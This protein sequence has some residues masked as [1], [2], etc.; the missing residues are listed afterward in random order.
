MASFS[1]SQTQ[2]MNRQS[3]KQK[4]I[5]YYSLEEVAGAGHPQLHAIKVKQNHTVTVPLATAQQF[6]SNGPGI[7]AYTKVCIRSVT[8]TP[9]CLQCCK[10]KINRACQDGNSLMFHYKSLLFNYCSRVGEVSASSG[11]QR[12]STDRV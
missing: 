5:C 7:I 6:H 8:F 11:P 12:R 10:V 4:K 9:N 1:S 3:N 2:G